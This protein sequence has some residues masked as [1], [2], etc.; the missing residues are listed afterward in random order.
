MITVLRE[1]V[2]RGGDDGRKPLP[3]RRPTHGSTESTLHFGYE[4]AMGPHRR[5]SEYA[6]PLLPHPAM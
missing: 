4:P 3:I 6:K 2:H 5:N 1:G